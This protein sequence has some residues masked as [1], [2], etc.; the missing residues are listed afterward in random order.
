MHVFV[1]LIASVLYHEYI[2][3]LYIF[4]N[5]FSPPHSNE[6]SI[7]LENSWMLVF[8]LPNLYSAKLIFP[9]SPNASTYLLPLCSFGVY[10][11]PCPPHTPCN[12][13]PNLVLVT[14]CTFVKKKTF[15]NMPPIH[16]MNV[17]LLLKL[18]P[19]LTQWNNIELE[20]SS[21]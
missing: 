16:S 20:A 9:H 3:Q 1:L 17:Y 8:V 7:M 19:Q 15:W 10:P 11:R 13:L 18:W 2:G 12:T 21:Y 6:Q 14:A 4:L 5:Y